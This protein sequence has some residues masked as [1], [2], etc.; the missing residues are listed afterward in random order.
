MQYSH[1]KRTMLVAV[2]ATSAELMKIAKILVIS[3]IDC[4]VPMSSAERG[5]ARRINWHSFQASTRISVWRYVIRINQFR[6]R[7]RSTG[8]KNWLLQHI[9]F[10]INV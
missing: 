3:R 7:R 6:I 5:S 2:N 1:Y 9:P 4:Q 8:S 10:P